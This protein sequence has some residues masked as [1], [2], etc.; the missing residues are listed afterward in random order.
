MFTLSGHQLKLLR[1]ARQVKQKNIAQFMNVSQQ[2]YSALE[3]NKEINAL[4]AAKALAALKL[5][6][7]DVE[8]ILKA[9]PKPLPLTKP[10]IKK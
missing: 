6:V 1:L 3:K 4:H 5:S 8:R 10:N 7:A 2:R 9:L